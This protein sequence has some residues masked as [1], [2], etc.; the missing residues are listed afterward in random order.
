[1][2]DEND[3]ISLLFSEEAYSMILDLLAPESECK[4]EGLKILSKTLAYGDAGSLSEFPT[5]S[6]TD[7]L[8][9]ILADNCD[10]QIVELVT[11]CI[12]FLFESLPDNISLYLDYG[13]LDNFKDTDS[14][15][16]SLVAENCIRTLKVFIEEDPDRFSDV[17]GIYPLIGNI[18]LLDTPEKRVAARMIWKLCKSYFK[19]EY[20][21]SIM[22]FFP[23]FDHQDPSVR[24][25][26]IESFFIVVENIQYVSQTIDPAFF[27][28]QIV[29]LINNIYDYPSLIISL[30]GLNHLIKIK[31][32]ALLAAENPINIERIVKDDNMGAHQNV[33][34]DKIMVYINGLLPNLPWDKTSKHQ[35]DNIKFS[36]YSQKVIIDMVSKVSSIDARIL[37]AL[38]SSMITSPVPLSEELI[39]VLLGVVNSLSQNVLFIINASLNPEEA[40]KSGLFSFLPSSLNDTE[41]DLWY[42]ATYK[43][44]IDLHGNNYVEATKLHFL[45]F[46]EI[47]DYVLNQ[48]HTNQKI[49]Y[50]IFID[51][52]LEFVSKMNDFSTYNREAIVSIGE[53]IINKVSSVQFP[54]QN[55]PLLSSPY[56]DIV[57]LN[58]RFEG[59]YFSGE[60]EPEPLKRVF[61]P[62]MSDFYSFETMISIEKGIVSDREFL[63]NYNRSDIRRIIEI[64]DPKQISSKLYSILCRSLEISFH[65]SMNYRINNH[66]YSAK[67]S[68]LKAL[69]ALYPNND[70]LFFPIT[71]VTLLKGDIPMYMPDIPNS[72]EL[73]YQKMLQFL[74]N[75]KSL[76]PEFDVLIGKWD[77]YIHSQT[78]NLYSLYS[79]RN[80]ALHTVYHYPS[81][82]SMETKTFLF[83][84]LSFNIVD[85]ISLIHSRKKAQNSQQVYTNDRCKCHIHRDS[86]FKD[87]IITL[88][89]TGSLTI[90]V[91]F[92]NEEGIGTGPTNEFFQLLARE[93]CQSSRKLWR[94]DS[95]ES[96]YCYSPEGLFPK[97][98]C[99]ASMFYYFGL[100]CAKS[101]IMDC[102]L[103]IPISN[104]F[105]KLVKG[106]PVNIEEV[107]LKLAKSLSCPEGLYDLSFEYPGISGLLLKPEYHNSYVSASNVGEYIN[108]VIHRTLNLTSIKDEFRRGFAE[109][110]PWSL[111]ELFSPEEFHDL[112]L[113]RDIKI[114]RNDILNSTVISHGYNE[115][116]EQVLWLFD[117]VSSFDQEHQS[118]FIKFVTGANRLPIGGLSSLNPRLT[119]ALRIPPENQSPDDSLPSVMTCVNYLKIPQ[120]SSES[121]MENKLKIAI[122]EGSGMFL[123]T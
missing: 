112:I 113:G 95:Y 15:S 43:K 57:V 73:K 13:L 37:Q 14:Y 82:F 80:L 39:H 71:Q 16:S 61:V 66:V 99:E 122:T 123:L 96:E 62:T 40:F 114:S 23:A 83:K 51:Q 41:Q 93:F 42:Q 120:Y 34:N 75:I 31:N 97:P 77:K 84:L 60:T 33:I 100:L 102:S 9:K 46:E 88:Q 44:L 101:L 78:F 25:L 6:V 8:V 49:M 53:Y 107:D 19:E 81:L 117:I 65:P 105:F 119:I 91:F 63:D 38:A 64:I 86:I 79:Y 48:I 47:V 35:I 74:V 90:D 27:I 12:R 108:L 26:L 121:I 92:D 98:D 55:D 72:I 30:N 28:K 7:S 69:C 2:F 11:H 1:M 118:L 109:I 110:I 52:L 24:S 5:D 4:E 116:S 36:K 10:I 94:S 18:K 32:F 29:S 85:S 76:I 21:Q 50:D 22:M 87:G 89:H 106:M 56:E 54:H 68:I 70:T 103:G 3:D 67:D 59:K 104:A 45:S 17:I 20:I 115:K 111:I 58:S